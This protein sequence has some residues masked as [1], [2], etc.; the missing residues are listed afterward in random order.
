[1]KFQNIL[2]LLLGVLYVFCIQAGQNNALGCSDRIEYKD[3]SFTDSLI[4]SLPYQ[5][6]VLN[7]STVENVI[8]LG[9]RDKLGHVIL[10]GKSQVSGFV[11]NGQVIGDE[12][13]N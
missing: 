13:H 8:F 1:M 9:M 2:Y 7:N 10:K 12:N 11:K 5:K 6:L 3:K 4:I